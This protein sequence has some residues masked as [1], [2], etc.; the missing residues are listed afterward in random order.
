MKMAYVSSKNE[1]WFPW[2]QGNRF[3]NQS[4]HDFVIQCVK[5]CF[6]DLIYQYTYLPTYT[7]EHLSI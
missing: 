6:H 3:T 2:P 1:Q 4:S 5:I 7:Y